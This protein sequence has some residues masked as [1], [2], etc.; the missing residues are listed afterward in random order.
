VVVA[1]RTAGARSL[2]EQHLAGIAESVAGMAVALALVCGYWAAGGSY[3]SAVLPDPPW[4]LQASRV[5]GAVTAVVGLLGLAGRWGHQARFW[6]PAALTWVG[7]GALAAFDGLALVAFLLFGTDASEPGWGQTDTVLL[8]KAVTGVLAG[9]V[10]ALAITAA[11][12]D[13][14]L[15]HA[16]PEGVEVR[17]GAAAAEGSQRTAEPSVPDR[18]RGPGAPPA[19]GTTR[20]Q[21][22]GGRRLTSGT[23]DPTER[24]HSSR[25]GSAGS[26][27]A[28][29]PMR[30]RGRSIRHVRGRPRWHARRDG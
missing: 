12:M 13:N 11:A 16:S 8:I 20:S 17:P 30:R 19:A 18:R 21:R 10:C 1:R 22:R 2:P 15:Q 26:A 3:G 28:G 24:R 27:S 6:L 9:A 4:G 25:H 23:D 14:H 29:A 5:V 7:S